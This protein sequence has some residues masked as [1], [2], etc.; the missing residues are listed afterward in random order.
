M[1]NIQQKNRQQVEGIL[2]QQCS[3]VKREQ[4]MAQL[5]GLSIIPSIIDLVGEIEEEKQDIIQQL[6]G[7]N[8]RLHS[9]L[10]QFSFGS[11]PDRDERIIRLCKQGLTREQMAKQVGML[12]WGVIKM[13]K[14]LSFLFMVCTLTTQLVDSDVHAEEPPSAGQASSS[15]APT[16]SA[17]QQNLDE[18]TRQLSNPVSSLWRSALQ[19]NNF[20]LN[21]A[22]LDQSLDQRLL[23]FQTV[24]PLDLTEEL[25]LQLPVACYG[26]MNPT[27]KFVSNENATLQNFGGGTISF[28]FDW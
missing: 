14:A 1:E 15:G 21:A 27:M 26:I 3:G 24:L 18:L 9:Q 5:E 8:R 28:H 16:E 23:N 13:K 2:S 12:K 22:P 7:E 11:N 6:Q 4:I 20:L 10:N 17:S 19:F 25:H